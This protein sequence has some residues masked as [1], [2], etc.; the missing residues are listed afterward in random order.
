M[1]VVG[2]AQSVERYLAPHGIG[3]TLF[4]PDYIATAFPGSVRRVGAGGSGAE[5]VSASVPYPAQTPEH[6]ADVLLAALDRGAFLA[7]A[8][9]GADRLLLLQAQGGLDP[10]TL[11][12][13]YFAMTGAAAGSAPD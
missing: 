7:S 12:P 5:P 2:L 6:A 13:S 8:T 3:V 11:A 4:A 1:A 10:S 9:E